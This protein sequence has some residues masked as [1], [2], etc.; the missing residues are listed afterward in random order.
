MDRG[1]AVSFL[2]RVEIDSR[3]CDGVTWDQWVA[4]NKS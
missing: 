3:D 4:D 1:E 2:P